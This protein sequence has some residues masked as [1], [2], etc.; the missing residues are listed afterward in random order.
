MRFHSFTH[1]LVHSVIP[2]FTPTHA[3]PLLTHTFLFPLPFLPTL[4]PSLPY[5]HHPHPSLPNLLPPLPSPDPHFPFLPT[6]TFPF[7]PTHTFASP[8]SLPHPI[9]HNPLHTTPPTVPAVPQTHTTQTPIIAAA[10]VSSAPQTL[11]YVELKVSCYTQH[12]VLYSVYSLYHVSLDCVLRV[13][14]NAHRNAQ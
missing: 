3:F 7:L 8:L 11:A 9:P 4:F 6:H 10:S 13:Y 2:S 1:S 12:L 14:N 5:P